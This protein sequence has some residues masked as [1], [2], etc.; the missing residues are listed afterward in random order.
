MEKWWFHFTLPPGEPRRKEAMRTFFQLLSAVCLM[1]ATGCWLDGPLPN[2]NGAKRDAPATST[3]SDPNAAEDQSTG[4]K[5]SETAA[6]QL[7]R[8]R[9]NG[10]QDQASA[11]P[12]A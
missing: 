9:E 11:G 6:E 10:R 3:A 4:A 8:R 5:P 12:Q 7:R 2:P 1:L